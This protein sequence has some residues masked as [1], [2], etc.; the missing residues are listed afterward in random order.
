MGP[1]KYLNCYRFR[2][3]NLHWSNRAIFVHVKQGQ[4]LCSGGHPYQCKLYL[5]GSNEESNLRPHDQNLTENIQE[6]GSIR[7]GSQKSLL[8]QWGIRRVQG[9]NKKNDCEVKRVAPGNH[10]CSILK[11]AIET[12]KDHFVC[13]LAGADVSFPMQLWYQLPTHTKLQLNLQQMSNIA[14]KVCAY[15][16]IHRHRNFMKQPFAPLGCLVQMHIKSNK[17]GSWDPHAVSGWNLRT[18]IKHHRMSNLFTS[19]PKQQEQREY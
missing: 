6:D 1:F 14:P 7:V 19:S 8:W 16:I 15:A 9:S 10:Q 5:H 4:P 3:R 11:R 18:S 2:R 12:T 13:V 17:R